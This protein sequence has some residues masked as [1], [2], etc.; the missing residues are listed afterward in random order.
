[1]YARIINGVVVEV[2]AGAPTIGPRECACIVECADG[3][4]VGWPCI[5]GHCEEPSPEAVIEASILGIVG[6]YDR[7][8]KGMKDRISIAFLQ[9]GVSEADVR[10]ALVAEWQSANA[11][12]ESE[13]LSLLGG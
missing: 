11:A 6:E 5:G 7:K 1:M 8:R 2:F 9:D 13:I 4:Q 12:E 10:A 3:C